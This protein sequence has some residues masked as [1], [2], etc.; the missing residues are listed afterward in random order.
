MHH[1]P[2]VVKGGTDNARH[3][4]DRNSRHQT[5]L[6]DIMNHDLFRVRYD[7]NAAPSTFVF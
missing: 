5:D 2:P 1:S 3:S 7:A 4:F 6:W